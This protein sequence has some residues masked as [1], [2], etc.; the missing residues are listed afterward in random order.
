MAPLA[1][2][3]VH[4]GAY[5]R[6]CWGERGTWMWC[7]GWIALA[8]ETDLHVIARCIFYNSRTGRWCGVETLKCSISQTSDKPL[9]LNPPMFSSHA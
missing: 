4:V 7:T 8:Q 6:W 9:A 2:H 3:A 5:N 1:S